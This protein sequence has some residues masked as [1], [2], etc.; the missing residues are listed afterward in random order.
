MNDASGRRGEREEDE[1]Q[2]DRAEEPLTRHER[3]KASEHRRL[4]ALTVYA[5]VRREGEEELRRPIQS[6][7][8]S[9]IAAGIAIST[10]ILAE[11]VLH[12]TFLDHPYRTA[13]ENLGYTLGFVL[14]IISR[15]QLFT[16]NTITVILPLLSE[17]ALKKLWLTAR[18]WSVVFVANLVG[19]LF[20]A[21]ITVKVGTTTPE[22]T[23]A[24]LEI[25]RHFADT[26]PMNALL[27]GIPAGF[28][29]AAIVWMLPSAKG[30]E[31]PVI[32]LFTYLIAMGEFT[33][34]IAGSTEIFLLVLEGE[35]A[36][37]PAVLGLLLPALAGNIIGGTGLFALLAYG[38]VRDEMEE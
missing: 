6:L 19:T 18:L 23:A 21:L 33:H 9:G 1:R 8:W 13:I 37:G 11:G 34:V 14:V 17:P 26:T 32:V 28:Y 15:L 27:Y 24:M 35:L 7:W 16:E 12:K 2:A 22:H 38:Q 4:S 5:V 25:S 29:V 3:D 20:T 30:L 36:V 10:S 31:V